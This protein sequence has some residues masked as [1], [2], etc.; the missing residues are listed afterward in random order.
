MGRERAGLGSLLGPYFLGE[1]A[2]DFAGVRQ[3]I[4]EIGYLGWNVGWIEPACWDIVGKER[5]SPVWKLLGGRG[6]SVRTYASSGEQR[7]GSAR[8]D[9][10]GTRLSE[11]FDACKLR[12]HAKT[13]AEDVTQI[14]EARAAVGDG[15]VLGVDANQGWRV[16]VI[17]DAPRWDYDRAFAFCRAAEDLGFTWVEEPLPMDDYQGQARLRQATGLAIAGGE[18]NGHGLPEFEVMLEKGCFDWYQPDA[19][20]T[21]GI[22]ATWAI[23]QRVAAAEAAYSPH[24]WTNGIGFAINLQLFAASPGRDEARLEYPLD[25]PGWVPEARDGLLAVPWLH[26]NGEITIPERPGLGFDIDRR[27]L[28]RHGKRFF[29]ATKARVAVRAVLDRGLAEAKELGDVRRRRL[30][31]RSRELDRS[32][33]DPDLD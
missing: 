8:A 14:R 13:L 12:V 11:G 3:R 6:G 10:I 27:A 24:T 5:G 4:R 30:E 1:R 25:P 23:V 31:A 21:G 19:I 20:F 15:P 9:E 28:R 32:Q 17:A 29:V 16:A 22:G 7:M 33:M 18:L 26:E 2:D